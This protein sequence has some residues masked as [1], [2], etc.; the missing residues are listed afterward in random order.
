MR[1]NDTFE[2][3]SDVSESQSL[4]GPSEP[5]QPPTKKPRE[6]PEKRKAQT[7]KVWD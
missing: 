5:Q 4:I 6:E 1:V 7:K 3:D 2:V